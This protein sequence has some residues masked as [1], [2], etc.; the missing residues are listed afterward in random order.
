VTVG[1]PGLT[2]AGAVEHEGGDASRRQRLTQAVEVH[3]P[4]LDAADDDRG[5]HRA[6]RGDE[7]A[8]RDAALGVDGEVLAVADDLVSAPVELG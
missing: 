8:R 1:K 5:G 2:L 7:P 4:A 6:T 3:A